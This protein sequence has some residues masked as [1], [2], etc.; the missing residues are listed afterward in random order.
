MY[1]RLHVV[2]AS[3]AMIARAVFSR[4]NGTPIAHTSLI[5]I[6][7]HTIE[8]DTPSL[9]NE[10]ADELAKHELNA[11]MNMTHDIDTEK[12]ELLFPLAR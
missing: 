6:R 5:H 1:G 9:M 7:S 12:Y 10:A 2:F 11:D 4:E 8:K 3:R